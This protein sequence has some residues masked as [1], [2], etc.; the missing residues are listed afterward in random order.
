MVSECTHAQHT[1]AHQEDR[2]LT[3]R[4]PEPALTPRLVLRDDGHYVGGHA[5]HGADLDAGHR[6]AQVIEGPQRCFGG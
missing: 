3:W 1:L 2:G 5:A 6:L 4:V